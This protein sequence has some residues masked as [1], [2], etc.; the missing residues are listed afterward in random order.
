MNSLMYDYTCNNCN[1][2]KEKKQRISTVPVKQE[3]GAY[4]MKSLILT[5]NKITIIFNTSRTSQEKNNKNY[6]K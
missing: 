1:I 5:E 2:F 6:S 4:T 3:I